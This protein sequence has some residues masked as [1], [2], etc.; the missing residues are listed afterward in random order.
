MV[1]Q[2]WKIEFLFKKISIPT[3]SGFI[4]LRFALVIVPDTENT[5]SDGA[6]VAGTHKLKLFA[7][8]DKWGYL[9]WLT[10][11]H[12][13]GLVSDSCVSFAKDSSSLSGVWTDDL[14]EMSPNNIS[15]TLFFWMVVS[16]S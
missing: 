15:R 10:F 3:F 9:L 8:F 11:H 16:L 1:L 13:S 4:Q 14:L 6:K 12:T 2:F 5:L 7:N